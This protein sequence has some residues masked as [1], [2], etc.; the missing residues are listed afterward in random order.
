[1]RVSHKCHDALI[2][3]EKNAYE[4]ISALYFMMVTFS[5]PNHN[6]HVPIY[7]DPT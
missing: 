7:N 1:M 4:E 2:T 5:L 3:H 6:S